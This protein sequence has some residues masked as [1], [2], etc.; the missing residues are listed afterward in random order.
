MVIF[1]WW[2]ITRAVKRGHRKSSRLGKG[3]WIHRF[4]QDLLWCHITRAVKW[5]FSLILSTHLIHKIDYLFSYVLGEQLFYSSQSYLDGS[6]YSFKLL[7]VIIYRY[8]P[9]YFIRYI[10]VQ[11]WNKLQRDYRIV[12]TMLPEIYL[13]TVGFSYHVITHQQRT[14]RVQLWNFQHLSNKPPFEKE[15]SMCQS[16]KSKTNACTTR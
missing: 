4:Q 11:R 8:K 7:V 16:I 14:A 10:S 12:Y 6:I 1:L 15:N 3:G 13:H 5:L 9:N 2:H